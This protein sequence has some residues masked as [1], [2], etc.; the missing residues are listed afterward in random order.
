MRAHA[1]RFVSLAF[2]GA[3]LFAAPAHAQWSDDEPFVL[4]GR[5][6][7][8]DGDGPIEPGQVVVRDGRIAAVLAADAAVPDRALIV[9]T[10]G[11]IYPGLMN[12]HNHMK[13]NFL[14]LYDLPEHAENSDDWP[15][16]SA[17]ERGVNDPATIV[18]KWEAFDRIEEALKYAEV[19]AIV[20]GE[21]S[22]QGAANRSAISRTLVRN[23]E[24]KNWGRD[25]IGQ[26][27][28]KLDS[29]FFGRLEEE[30][31]KLYAL[32]AW[33]YHLCEG[34]D[35]EARTWWTYP[36]YD[37]GA[38]LSASQSRYNLPG[39][40]E[41]ELVWPGL[42]GIH[43]TAMEPED[44]VQWA[45][46]ARAAP[47]V[48]WSP[49]SN[50]LLYGETTDIRAA[51][52]AGAVIALGTDWAPS[53]PKNLLWELKAVDRLNQ[54]ADPPIFASDREIVELVTVNG[55]KVL[56]WEDQV[57]RVK[58]GLAADL[59]VVDGLVEDGYRNLIQAREEH[60]QL[61][62]IGGNPLYGDLGRMERLKTIDGE[63]HYEVMP[64]SPP[65][66]TKAID[67]H[68]NTRV[69]KGDMTLAEV[70]ARLLEAASGDPA[71][72]AEFVNSSA[73]DLRRMRKW[74]AR[75]Y[76]RDEEE[77]PADLLAEGEPLSVERVTEFI[78][79]KYPDF[80]PLESIDPIFTDEA[81]FA[82]LEGN[83]HWEEEEYDVDLDLRPYF[84]WTPDVTASADEGEDDAPADA[85]GVAGVVD[86]AL[87]E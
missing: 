36:A 6:V 32:R 74:L 28:L 51:R 2:L 78:E 11:F 5:V 76:R 50:L 52:A 31:P 49:T 69:S 66:R 45:E 9:E 37:P 20:G 44:F 40:V 75:D 17:Y 55:A 34:I 60:I 71:A 41:A 73:R 46:I 54:Q 4:R 8:M 23:V 53:G 16:G 65:A 72:L 10:D 38:P 62:L 35:E 21:T 13:Y 81:Y 18:T 14:G 80:V 83:L 42:V 12:L 1:A 43:C 82:D 30:R 77:V 39:M 33:I 68:E 79:R 87:G 56:D 3:A 63:P 25:D 47:R 19:K 70:K 67:M 58:A 85:A 27:A 29:R 22:I 48:V 15:G 26:S 84:E 64:D 86:E 7:T 59:V 57:G 61:V 24:L